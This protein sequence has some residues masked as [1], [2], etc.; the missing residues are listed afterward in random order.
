MY[1][2]PTLHTHVLIFWARRENGLKKSFWLLGVHFPACRPPRFMDLEGSGSGHLLCT[3]GSQPALA[4]DTI[5]TSQACKRLSVHRLTLIHHR[6]WATPLLQ[7]HSELASQRAP[8]EA[9]IFCAE[10]SQ[11]YCGVLTLRQCKILMNQTCAIQL[12]LTDFK[13][14]LNRKH[15]GKYNHRSTLTCPQ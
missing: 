8:T 11:S 2:F 6:R 1:R 3:H 12:N 9:T 5:D 13:S 10:Q 14:Y 15:M 7:C 4:A